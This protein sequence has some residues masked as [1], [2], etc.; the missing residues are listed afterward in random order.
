MWDVQPGL[1]CD[2]LIRGHDLH[3]HLREAHGIHGSDLTRFFCLWRSCHK[4][5]NKESLV[6]LEEMHLGIRY[7]RDCGAD[8]LRRDT[9]WRH[10]RTCTGL[11][12]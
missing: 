4:E 3:A 7:Y 6:H 8:F 11:Q 12:R 10:K 1:H 5:L 9:L 2:A